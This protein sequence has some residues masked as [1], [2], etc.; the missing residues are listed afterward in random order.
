[1]AG[2]PLNPEVF[3][4]FKEL[5]GLTLTEAFGQSETPAIIGI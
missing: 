3:Y 5:T 1:M 2:E 4:R